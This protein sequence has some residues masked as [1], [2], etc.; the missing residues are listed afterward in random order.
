ME[1]VHYVSLHN[2]NDKLD[3]VCSI[4]IDPQFLWIILEVSFTD[5]SHA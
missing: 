2:G 4:G 3:M 5:C 1:I